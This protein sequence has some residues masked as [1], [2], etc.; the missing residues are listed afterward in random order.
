MAITSTLTQFQ[1]ENE[2]NR[3]NCE[4]RDAQGV[5]KTLYDVTRPYLLQIKEQDLKLKIKDLISMAA[6]TPELF[7]DWSIYK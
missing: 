7:S 3:V 2:S 6:D 4:R 1:L 5:K